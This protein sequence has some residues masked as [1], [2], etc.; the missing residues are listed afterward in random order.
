[1]IVLIIV[2]ALLMSNYISS[3]IENLLLGTKKFS[4]QEFDYRIKVSSNDEI[5]QLEKSFNEM[6]LKIDDLIKL[7]LFL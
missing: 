2:I 6:A 1:M 7:I 4:N 5:G 3:K